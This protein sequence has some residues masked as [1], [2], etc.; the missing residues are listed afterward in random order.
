MHFSGLT[1][2]TNIDVWVLSE[3]PPHRAFRDER[4]ISYK[5]LLNVYAE[6]LW[7]SNQVDIVLN[8]IET[9]NWTPQ[10]YKP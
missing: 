4:K 3:S 2:E 1:Y 6:T 5:C 10:H 8:S 9:R 7:S